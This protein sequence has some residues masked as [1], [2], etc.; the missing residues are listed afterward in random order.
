MPTGNVG[1]VAYAAPGGSSESYNI[2][3]SALVLTLTLLTD[4][5]NSPGVLTAT[6]GNGAPNG[7]ASFFYDAST[8]AFFTADLDDTGAA[9]SLYLPVTGQL[10]GAHTVRVSADALP[11]PPGGQANVAYTVA[12]SKDTGTITPTTGS[13]P[14]IPVFPNRW[15][16]QAYDF[17]D[18]E[19]VDTY[20]LTVNPTS[21]KRV[22]GSQNITD[23][24]TVLSEG[25][26][27][28]WEGAP[29]PPRWDFSGH[30]LTEADYR[31][32]L[33]WGTTGQRFYVTDHFGVRYLVKVQSFDVTR[34]RDNARPYHHTYQMSVSVLSGTGVFTT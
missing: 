33:K 31:E 21:M 15:V 2:D 20:V 8:T 24:P 26:I 4:T 29:K 13:E 10:A 22:F 11:P 25:K 6:V 1:R 19:S 28:S 5:V 18:P 30:I 3:R 12:V 7:T 14:P 27:I 9:R 16:F 34:V 32:F 23:E 17:S